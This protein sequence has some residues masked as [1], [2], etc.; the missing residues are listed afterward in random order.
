MRG[1]YIRDISIVWAGGES[2]VPLPEA[3][4]VVV[5]RSFMKA[6]LQFPLDSMLV[7]VL[8]TF[9]IY[10]HQLTPEAIIKIGVYIWAMRSQG[11]EPNEKSF[12]N[13]H[14]L[15]YETKATG[16][17]Q[18]HNN[19][20]CYGFV[21]CSEVSNLVP[22][23]RKRWPG[24]W[25]Q[26]WFYVKND[27]IEREDI[28]G[29]IQHPMWSQFDIRRPSLALE[30]DI[31]ACQ[32]AY[33]T[34]CTYIGTRD[35]VQEH[36]A[37]KVWPLE[38]GWEMPKETA[39][40]SSQGGLVYLNYTFKFRSQFDEPNDDWLD[41]IDATS[42]ELLGAYSRV[43]DDAMTVV[44]GGRGK[45]RL[46]RVF[47]VI[48]FVYP[49]Y[50]YPSRKQGKKRRAAAS[51]ISSTPKLKKIKVLT[52]RPR[53]IETA[54]VPKLAE[55]PSSALEL[56]C[57]APAEAKTESF[58]EPKLKIAAERVKALSPLQETEQL[59]VLKVVSVTP[60]R[61]RM[62]SILDTVMESTKALTPALQKHLAWK[63]RTQRNVPK[64]S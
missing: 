6:G 18:Y 7:E 42:D 59:K 46:N 38:N 35:L 26:E 32:V 58:E 1:R 24:A 56:N 64:P 25:M 30:N 45:K 12:C 29:I 11:Q 17:E 37:F 36:I 34:V 55:G 20:G 48:G 13:M 8:K 61:R 22:T 27:L 14:E 16:K 43:E 21:T 2:N 15:S 49:D 3:D 33:N 51:T 10:L 52:H 23:F 57:P 9:E 44:F 40:G 53:H 28:K 5:Y 54:E 41:A 50:S 60:K 4:E 47:E 39:A 63:T 19:F 31:Q 62:A